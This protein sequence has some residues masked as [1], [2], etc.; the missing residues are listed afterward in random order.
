MDYNLVMLVVYP[1]N[2]KKMKQLEVFIIKLYN[3]KWK[4]NIFISVKIIAYRIINSVH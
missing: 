4:D 2:H 3:Q 1:K